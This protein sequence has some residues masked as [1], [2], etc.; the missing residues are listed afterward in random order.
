MERDLTA[1]T[2]M[3]T[4]RDQTAWTLT[5]MVKVLTAWTLMA[6]TMERVL[7]AQAAAQAQALLDRSA[8]REEAAQ[9]GCLPPSGQIMVNV[10]SR[11]GVQLIG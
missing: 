1:W 8:A 5:T 7:A 2:L 6:T 3:M 10:S 11:G 4:E 9:L